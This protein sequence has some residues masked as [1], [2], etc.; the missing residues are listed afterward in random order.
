[1]EELIGADVELVWMDDN[2]ILNGG[3]GAEGENL[4]TQADGAVSLDNYFDGF[5]VYNPMQD[6]SSYI[7][8]E[9]DVTYVNLVNNLANTSNGIF[10]DIKDIFAYVE[11]ATFGEASFAN[12]SKK[13]PQNELYLANGSTGVS[14]KVNLPEGARVMLGVR[15]VSGAPKLTVNGNAIAINSATEM[16]YDI[17]KYLTATN[18]VATV[19]ITNS[20]T[21]LLA[22]NNM[23][24][25]GATTASVSTQ[26]LDESVALMSLRPVDVE[27]TLPEEETVVSYPG[28]EPVRDVKNPDPMLDIDVES[29]DNSS[30]NGDNQANNAFQIIVNT[31]SKLLNNLLSRILEFI[32]SI[33][34]AF[35]TIKF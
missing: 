14:F 35:S 27:Y 12:Y 15:A 22:V 9:Q 19:A 28:S 18:G 3:T 34:A 16:Y 30:S 23:K 21:G 7:A 20:G 2:S 13:G 11:G 6:Q 10:T 5:R 32:R 33:V 25:V 26:S 17:T 24:L 29:V 31:L 4:S 8:N 1:M